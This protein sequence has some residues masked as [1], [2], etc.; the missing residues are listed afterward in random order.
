[1][2]RRQFIIGSSAVALHGGLPAAEESTT[3]GGYAPVS[4]AERQAKEVPVLPAG[5]VSAERFAKRC[6]GCHLCTTVCPTKV[7]RP[8]TRLSRLGKVELDFR[9]GY[10]RPDCNRC[11]AVCPVN[12]I[13]RVELAETPSA[14]GGR[15][16]AEAPLKRDVHVGFAVW[17]RERCVRVTAGD[18]CHACEKHC[19]VRAIRIV[20]GFP[21]VDTNA[22]I[23]CG[24]CEH[25]CPSRPLTAI[26]VVAREYHR[27]VTPVSEAD[28]IA[29]M[30]AL[31]AQGRTLVVAKDGVIVFL[32]SD[33]MI[34]P[35]KAAAAEK[36]EILRGAV[37]ADK[38][39]GK[40]AAKMHAEAGVRKIVTPLVSEP[41]KRYLESRGIAVLADEVVPMILNR[42]RTGQCPLDAATEL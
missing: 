41:A 11:G 23:G 17:T 36:G 25:Y 19:P 10:C 24:A 14:L 38:V 13:G 34:A 4:W 39:V 18:V 21:F 32:S 16:A 9:Y 22:C 29:E 5:A 40:A 31:L 27:V 6:I 30:K 20:D 37:V 2:N 15:D 7:L 1:M 33:R 26:R 42:D 8:S 12:A 3:D 28:L 35:I